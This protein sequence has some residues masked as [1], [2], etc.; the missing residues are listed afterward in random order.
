VEDLVTPDF[1]RGRRVILT[2]HTGFKGSWLALWLNELGADVTGYA[3][4]PPTEPNLYDIAHIGETLRSVI[5]D[6]RD[7]R[8]L[9]EAMRAARPQVLL[10]LAAQPLVSEGYADPVGTYATNV[11]GTVNVLEA[12]RHCRD[13][14]SI[15]VVTTDKCYDNR[16][17]LHDYN[18]ADPLGGRDPYSSSKACTELVT[19]AYRASY[20]QTEGAPRIAT[21]RAGNVIGG[22]DWAA[23]RLVPDLLRAFAEDKSACLRHPNAVRPW[24][25][26]LDPLAGYLLLAEKL[27][28]APAFARAWNFGP[29]LT[30]CVSTGTLAD[31]AARHWSPSARWHSE[32]TK[33]PHEAQLLQLN[34]DAA[35]QMLKWRPKWPLNEA[36]RHTVAWHRAWLSGHDMQSFSR[37]QIQQYL[38]TT[39]TFDELR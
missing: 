33:L 11:M 9:T 15:V 12:A 29:A 4:A 37:D 35:Q 19:A 30:D 34:T 31:L 25:H 7:A 2:G 5:D 24:Q 21:A 16:E 14:E 32:P 38:R 36:V 6:I 20:F 13:L 27:A 28:R 23:N 22:G 1:W 39:Q 10:H 3:L 26:V 18:E 8:A 17:S